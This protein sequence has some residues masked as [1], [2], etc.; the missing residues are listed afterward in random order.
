L[1]LQSCPM[2]VLDGFPNHFGDGV[3]VHCESGKSG[4]GLRVG[5]EVHLDGFGWCVRGSGLV[6]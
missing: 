6:D 3:T 5:P 4:S 2:C 1:L